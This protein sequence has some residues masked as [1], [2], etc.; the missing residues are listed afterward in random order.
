MNE[1]MASA[2]VPRSFSIQS[3]ICSF[4]L[5]A[6]PNHAI[7][8]LDAVLFPQVNGRPV[9]TASPRITHTG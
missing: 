3:N 4:V 8:N 9:G 2:A 7:M 5:I 6:W 1:F